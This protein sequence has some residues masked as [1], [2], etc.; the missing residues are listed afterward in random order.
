LRDLVASRSTCTAQVSKCP[1]KISVPRI[2]TIK[3]SKDFFG[4]L[5][6]AADF[7]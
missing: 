6:N 1:S 2:G 4:A 5:P 3:M 7:A